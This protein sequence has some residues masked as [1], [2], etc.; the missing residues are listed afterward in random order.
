MDFEKKIEEELKAYQKLGEKNPGIDTATLM[1][2]AL[3]TRN[4]NL[5]SPRGKKWAYLISVGLP[6]LGLIFALRYY[7]GTEDNARPAALV[8]VILTVIGLV[9]LW[10][11]GNILFSG[12]GAS[13]EQLQQITPNDLRQL[14]Q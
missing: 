12:S 11:F 4:A 14:T 10:L 3:Q 8:C 2:N 9:G 7:F 13:L 6:P 1:I 5:V